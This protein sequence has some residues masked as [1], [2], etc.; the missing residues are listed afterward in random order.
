MA[1]AI[2]ATMTSSVAAD[3]ACT[4]V[5]EAGCRLEGT[6]LVRAVDETRILVAIDLHD[7][8]I[9]GDGRVDHLFLITHLEKTAGIPEEALGTPTRGV[10]FIGSG[11]T[12]IEL[13]AGSEAHLLLPLK[14]TNWSH[15]FG[16]GKSKLKIEDLSRAT[17]SLE[18]DHVAGS[19]WRVDGFSINFP[20]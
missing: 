2:I 11:A 19:C 5:T 4:P 9:A 14:Y 1:A 3:D 6:F 18:C 8:G 13:R 17:R 20:S 10:L 7:P 12:Q 16:F 15:I